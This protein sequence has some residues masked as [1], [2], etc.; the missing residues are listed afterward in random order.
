[1]QRVLD[2]IDGHADEA[3]DVEALSGIAAFSKYHFHRQFSELFGVTVHRYLRLVR[4]K[5]ASYRLAFRDAPI[6]EVAL[7][8]GYEA[9]EA[10]S[11][12]F[13]QHFGQTPSA[14]RK[15]PKWFPWH[16]AFAPIET[17]RRICT[18]AFKSEQ[19]RIVDFPETAVAILEHRGDARRVGD[20]IRRFIGWR[21]RVGLPPRISATFNILL[22]HADPGNVAPDDYRLDLCA[23]TDQP[24]APNEEGVIAGTIPS[25]RCA[26]LRLIGSSDN[27]QPAINFLY[28]DWLPGSGEELRDFPVHAQRIRFF[29]DVPETDAVTDIFLPLK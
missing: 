29:P 8:G 13:R 1:M 15:E 22:L 28:A 27:L 16:R 6:L 23:A 3:L 20:S 11:R 21:K 2:H 12:A 5:R 25:G 9:P 24:I 17:A 4:L 10:F 7:D 19:V 14:F 26:V 18:A